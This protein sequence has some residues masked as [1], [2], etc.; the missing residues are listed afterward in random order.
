MIILRPARDSDAATLFDWRNDDATRAAS[1]NRDKVDWDSHL[2]WFRQSLAN[3]DR[4]L[5]I[6]ER[7]GRPV[8]T[9]RIDRGEQTELSWTIAPDARRTGVGTEM[10]TKALPR[11][12]VIA[13]IRQD[14]VASQKIARAA[15]FAL[16]E[17]GPLQ[18]WRTGRVA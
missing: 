5:L 8:G 12:L 1:K 14:N 10:V 2:A 6:A 4:D 3:P 16:A 17:D 9:V 13:H 11:G 18:I 7:D 15:G